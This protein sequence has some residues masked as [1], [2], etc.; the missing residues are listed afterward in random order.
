[1]TNLA[2][3]LV[4]S[5]AAG[6]AGLGVLVSAEE[7]VRPAAPTLPILVYHQVMPSSTLPENPYDG[8]PRG[9][10]ED[11]LR[12]LRDEGYTALSMDDVL[13]FLDG[14]P[15]PEKSVAIHMD[16]GW[17]SHV[18]AA[19]LLDRYGFKASFWVIPGTGIGEPHLDWDQI[20]AIATRPRLEV[21]SHTMTHPWKPN[22]T[23]IDWLA[24]RT[25]GRGIERA[26]WEIGESK[27]LL[28]ARLHRPV[29]YLAW[30]SGHYNDT[31]VDLAVAAGYRGLV[32]IDEGLNAPGGDR[33][34]IR[35]TLVHGACDVDDLKALLRD[36][37]ARDCV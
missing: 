33:F 7:P 28:E 35:R 10:F 36:G 29:P 25:P 24:G 17:R 20:E 5:A 19:D 18:E 30:P 11:H 8:I 16:D 2:I 21:L 1:M 15:M 34:R 32:T 6:L 31:L 27:R 12:Y 22:E 4:L 3:R 23:L 26:G 9:R 14:A 37:K 13:A